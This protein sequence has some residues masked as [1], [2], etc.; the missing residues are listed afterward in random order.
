[1]S[2]WSPEKERNEYDDEAGQTLLAN[3]PLPLEMKPID[4]LDVPADLTCLGAHLDGRLLVRG[5]FPTEKVASVQAVFREPA[6]LGM[7]VREAEGGVL[8]CR[9]FALIDARKLAGDQDE[10]WRASLTD[11]QDEPELMPLEIGLIVRLRHDR[12]FPDDT[13]AEAADVFRTVLL[14]GAG[15]VV[16]RLL[17]GI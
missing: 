13:A 5:V 16:D 1:M 10:P 8:H 15:E 2:D 6:V 11:V 3:V 9:F 17:G 7:N 4:G 14:G 12:K